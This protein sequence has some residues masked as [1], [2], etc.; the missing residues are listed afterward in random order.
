M[1]RSFM[2]RMRS[3]DLRAKPPSPTE[4][5]SSMTRMSGSTLVASAN[6]SRTNIPLE[7]VLTGWSMK[8]PMP[9]NSMIESICSSSCARPRPSKGPLS[10]T[11]SRPEKSGLK[12]APSSSSAAMR[13]STRTVPVVGVT[14][15][16]SSC[17]SVDLPAPLLP[18]TPSD[19]PLR[20]CS[21]TSRSAQKLSP[22]ISRPSSAARRR[23]AG[24][25]LGR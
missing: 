3:N 21:D 17:N 14:V 20:T 15:P 8:W 25:A 12:P 6:A 5:A 7:Y 9:E 19:S 4:R 10:S 13:P 24:L 16:H 11:L 2:A 18:I 22:G 1:P 23:A